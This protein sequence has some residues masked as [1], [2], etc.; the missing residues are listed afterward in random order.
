M[1]DSQHKPVTNTL[2]REVGIFGATMMGLGAIV[3]TGSS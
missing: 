2:R 3:G 1:T